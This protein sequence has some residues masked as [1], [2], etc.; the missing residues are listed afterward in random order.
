MAWKSLH[1]ATPVSLSS[2]IWHFILYTLCFNSSKELKALWHAP[3][4]F[5]LWHFCSCGSSSCALLYFP[6]VSPTH[7]STQCRC[8]HLQKSSPTW[9]APPIAQAWPLLCPLSSCAYLYDCTHHTDIIYL[10]SHGFQCDLG[11][12]TSTLWACFLIQRY[13]KPLARWEYITKHNKWWLY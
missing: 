1:S 3:Y 5:L 8:P 2:P 9:C 13:V 7:P 6:G 4:C 10:L 12:A 11:W